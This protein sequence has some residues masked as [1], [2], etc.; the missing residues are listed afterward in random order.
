MRISFSIPLKP[1]SGKHKF[2]M[3][4]AKE[5][6]KQ[7]IRV[8]DKKPHVNLVFLKGVRNKCKNIFRLDGV[9]MNTRVN[10]RK[11]NKKLIKTIAACDAVIYQNKFC[12]QAGVA[13]LG[14]FRKHALLMN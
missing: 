13:C 6:K 8:T 2:A 1:L 12:K 14:K 10:Y 3:R 11:K 5:M 9:L 4:L 7:G